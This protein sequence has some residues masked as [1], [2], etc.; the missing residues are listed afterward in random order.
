MWIFYLNYKN[1]VENKQWTMNKSKCYTH[2]YHHNIHTYNV[3]TI[4]TA[5]YNK[6]I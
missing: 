4:I 2:V 6:S 3:L 5:G 1:I